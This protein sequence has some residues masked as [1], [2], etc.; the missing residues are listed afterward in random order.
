MHQWFIDELPSEHCGLRGV[1]SGPPPEADKSMK[2]PISSRGFRSARS[3]QHDDRGDTM[4]E[5]DLPSHVLTEI[6]SPIR[7]TRLSG[8]EQLSRLANGADLDLAAAA[9]LALHRLCSD[10]S[11]SVAAAAAEALGR[12]AMRLNPDRVDFG[13]V[14][15]WTPRLVADVVVEGPPLAVG[16]SSVTVSGPGL[17]AMLAGNHLRIVW[18]PRSEWLDGLVTVRGPAGWADVRVT[19]QVPAT[20][21]MSRTD[22]EQ[23]LRDAGDAA[24]GLPPERVTV[25]PAPPMRRRAGNTVLIACMTVLALVGGVGVAMALTAGDPAERPVAAPVTPGT[26]GSGAAPAT[27]SGTAPAYAPTSVATIP[28]TSRVVSVAQPAVVGT[29]RVGAEPE[30][31]AVSPDGRTVYAANQSARMLS[32]VDVATRRVT[33]VPLRNTPRFVAPS[34]EGRLVFVSMYENDKSGSGVAVVDTATRR[35]VRYLTSGVQPYTLSVGPDGRLW[36]PIHGQRRV[37]IYSADDQRPA[38]R[39]TVP[40]NPHAVGFSARTGRAFT[41]D[42]ESDVVSVIDTRSGRLLRSL[43]VSRAPHSLA[44]SPDGTTVLVAGYEA[45]AADLIDAA[46]LRRRGPFRVGKQPQSVAFAADGRHAYVVNE[47][48]DTVSVL[49]GRTGAATATIKV[50]HSP[51]TV[52]VSP[53]GRQ[54]YVSNGHDNTITVLRV[55][56]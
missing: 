25:L 13:Q 32:V 20:G 48:D 50:G 2:V 1:K 49:D 36:V 33:S 11:R 3:S 19:G 51:R 8:V 34:H 42:H 21:P 14:P 44:V 47:G 23:R 16:A 56:E 41:P 24:G 22:V 52:A 37:D 27:P 12:T 28:L 26:A 5:R 53:D 17:R 7:E 43:P 40:P 35:V 15:P 18:V 4:S 31:V 10:D 9:R 38:G 46:T 6:G 30:G 55:G 45:N 54:A 29:V 39:V